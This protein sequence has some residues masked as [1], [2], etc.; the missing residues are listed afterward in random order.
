MEKGQ[1]SKKENIRSG[2]SFFN[3]GKKLFIYEGKNCGIND[4]DFESNKQKHHCVDSSPV[5]RAFLTIDRESF[6][7]AKSLNRTSK[8]KR[9]EKD[10]SKKLYGRG[11]LANTFRVFSVIKD[12]GDQAKEIIRHSKRDI[13]L[14]HGNPVME[15]L[16]CDKH[17][18]KKSAQFKCKLSNINFTFH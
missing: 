18:D 14:F 6:K 16:K 10:P 4:K 2:A 15:L 11:F 7:K 1:Q 9:K 13:G 12:I 3:N 17:D 8:E 5:E